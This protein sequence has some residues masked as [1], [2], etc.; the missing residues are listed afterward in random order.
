MQ[1]DSIPL[2]GRVVL[3]T[4]A[5]SGLGAALCERLGTERAHVAALDIDEHK[6]REVAGRLCAQ[7]ADIHAHVADVGEAG[8]VRRVLDAVLDRHGRLD[9][10]VNCA[11]I[12]VTAPVAQ[13]DEATWERVLRTNLT[14]P[15]VVSR[16]ACGVL[17]RGGQI[18]N[19][20]STAARRAWPNACAYHA[21]KWGLMGLT[22]ALHAELRPAGIKVSAVIAGGMRT[23]FLL[24][25]FP[26][27][28]VGT[29]QEP[30]R[31]ARAICCVLTQPEDSVIPE[32]MVLPMRETSWP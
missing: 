6:V 1:D 27:I 2:S 19:V 20:A 21:S 4:G 8:A 31:V 5:G 3:V 30:S 25:R 13:I 9:A 22:Q 16:Q 28:D 17:P 24:D 29:L 10:V 26:D 23:P 32:I 18:V 15:F 14:G 7:G 12:D 11:A